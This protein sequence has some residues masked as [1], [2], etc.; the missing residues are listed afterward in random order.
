M[1][2]KDAEPRDAAWDRV[3]EQFA[4][5]G[6]RLRQR[7]E[8][9]DV[10]AEEPAGAESVQDALR[11]LGDAAERLATTIGS[12][13]RDPEVQADAKRAASSLMDALGIT[14]SQVSEDIRRRRAERTGGDDL[15]EEPTVEEIERRPAE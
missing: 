1:E 4:S 9:S 6:D 10:A 13:V 15:W 12:A 14:F 7:Y 3:S 5:L 8:A 2:S 11:T